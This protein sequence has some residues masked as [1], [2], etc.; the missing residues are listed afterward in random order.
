MVTKV[1]N[2]ILW[3]LVLAYFPVLFAF[4]SNGKSKVVCSDVQVVVKDSLETGFITSAQ[5]R[6]VLLKKYPAILGN[7]LQEVD[8]EEIEQFIKK[9][10]AIKSC[11][12]Y[13]TVGGRLN[14]EL[15]QRKPICRVFSG[16]DSWYLDENG[17]EMPLFKQYAAHT[18]VV[19]GHM[20]KLDSLNEVIDFVKFIN[21]NEFWK[22]Q[23]EQVYVESNGEFSLAPRVGDQIIHLGSLEN[24][25]VKMRNL[26]ALYKNGLHPREWNNYKEINL[27]FEG[28]VI[29]TKK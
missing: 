21:A 17:Y 26:Y 18:L 5:M 9:H 1:K 8:C 3:G 27:K 24:Y 23:I 13:Y 6:N 4:V 29:C 28:Q 15:E 12:A 16:Y 7:A 2:M 20:N 10:E 14:V 22:A 19:S 11:E 25:P